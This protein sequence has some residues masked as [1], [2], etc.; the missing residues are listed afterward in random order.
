MDGV[1]CTL[2]ELDVS[3]DHDCSESADRE[4]RVP[5]ITRKFVLTVRCPDGER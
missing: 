4:F 2:L 3:R 1:I 5:H